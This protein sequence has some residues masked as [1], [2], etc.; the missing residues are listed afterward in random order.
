MIV[1]GHKLE[2]NSSSSCS[3]SLIL[4]SFEISGGW[5]SHLRWFLKLQSAN[6]ITTL[7]Y[8]D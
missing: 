5:T 4:W 7:G 8:V 3:P 6:N 2:N 1:V